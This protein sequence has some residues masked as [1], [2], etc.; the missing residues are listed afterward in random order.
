MHQR[1]LIAGNFNEEKSN[2][3]IEIVSST[4]GLKNSSQSL[5]DSISTKVT[6]ILPGGEPLVWE[7]VH[8]GP[9]EEDDDDESDEDMDED[10]EEE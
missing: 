7:S 8:Q 5:P 4:L 9:K 6:E 1:L 3:L 2:E 10:G